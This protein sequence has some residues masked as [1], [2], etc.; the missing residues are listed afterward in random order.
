MI[1]IDKDQE[2]CQASL[3][4]TEKGKKVKQIKSRTFMQEETLNPDSH[5]EVNVAFNWA[6]NLLKKTCHMTETE[7]DT[8]NNRNCG[9]VRPRNRPINST[10]VTDSTLGSAITITTSTVSSIMSGFNI[11]VHSSSRGSNLFN[12][13]SLS[14][15]GTSSQASNTDHFIS[16]SAPPVFPLLVLRRLIPLRRR[17]STKTT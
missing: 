3:S 9:F 15:F 7:T 11:V 12:Q 10:K 13:I 5:G 17:S 8:T 4:I 16:G 1:V 2:S 6:L 14:A